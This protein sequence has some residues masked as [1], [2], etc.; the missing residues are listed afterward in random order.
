MD[1]RYLLYIDILGFSELVE[2]DIT[3]IDDLYTV[4]ASLNVHE[5]DAFKTIVFSD[6]ILVYNLYGF[7]SHYD[8]HYIIM[9]LCEFAKD[10][11]HKL[12]E[13]GIF[14]RAVIM[15]GNFKYYELNSV[16]CFFGTALIDA[17]KAEK[18]IKAIGLFI[19]KSIE[20]N[21]VIF[22]TRHYNGNFS[23]VFIT[24]SLNEIEYMYEGHFPIP[25][26]ILEG[27]VDAACG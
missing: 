16:P 8:E 15:R 22:K 9:F 25:A 24:Q 7:E 18:Q 10:L 1:N 27:R 5:H 6:T 13:R 2:K 20:N 17:Y 3:Q 14:F 11:Q 21:S 19:D 23:F 26:N 12:T 4:I